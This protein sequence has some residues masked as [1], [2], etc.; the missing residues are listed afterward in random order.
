[1]TNLTND[2]QGADLARATAA[3]L[4]KAAEEAIATG[5]RVPAD[6]KRVFGPAYSWWRLIC[7]TAEAV[8]L[9]TKQ[10]FTV[11]V[12]PMVR[13]ILNH[14]YAIHWLVDN[15]DAAV[16]ALV[17]R[18]GDE[19]EKL[20]KKLEETGWPAAAEFR[21]AMDQAAAQQAAPPARTPAEQALHDK[22]KHELKNFYDLL[23]R[24]DVA[25]IYPVYSHL[26]S[27]SHT[28]LSTASA[29]VEQVA[30]GSLQIRP[31]A[32]DLGHAD[33]IQ[34]AVA[35]LQ[36][37]TVVSPLIE[38]DPLRPSID[39]ALADLGLQS[40]QLLPVRVK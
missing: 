8:L 26:S 27:L 1:M 35:L 14:A 38:S 39:Q 29:Y 9:L 22:L 40:T 36:A 18:G 30:D 21:A 32:V 25:E 7:R 31:N 6:K 4:L 10:G 3:S 2:E 34:L 16:D 19:R 13:N 37:S 28:T 15:G 24:Y 17:A 5:V 23:D 12:A 20:A 33:I 11:E